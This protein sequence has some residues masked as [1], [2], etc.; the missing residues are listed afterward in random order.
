M[1]ELSILAGHEMFHTWSLSS[2]EADTRISSSRPDWP[3]EG[4]PVSNKTE[5]PNKPKITTERI[6]VIRVFPTP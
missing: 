1:A 3:A 5:T 2:W 6:E 4:D